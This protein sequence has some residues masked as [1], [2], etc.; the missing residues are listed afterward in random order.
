MRNWFGA[1]AGLVTVSVGLFLLYTSSAHLLKPIPV[2]PLGLVSAPL[3]P[4]TTTLHEPI[5][6]VPGAFDGV[7]LENVRELAKVPAGTTRL[8]IPLDLVKPGTCFYVTAY[9]T[10]GNESAPSAAICLTEAP[11][12]PKPPAY[13]G[14][15]GSC[16]AAV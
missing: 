15:C 6:E 13:S 3:P 8:P 11:P 10:S 14:P 9:D 1:L 7:D 4:L 16:H 12:P 2:A 5:P